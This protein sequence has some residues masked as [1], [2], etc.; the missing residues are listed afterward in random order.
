MQIRRSL[1]E[2]SVEPHHHPK[3]TGLTQIQRDSTKNKFVRIC[4]NLWQIV[5]HE[6]V[7]ILTNYLL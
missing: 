1:R 5:T 4:A 7:Q 3:I 6:L 2:A